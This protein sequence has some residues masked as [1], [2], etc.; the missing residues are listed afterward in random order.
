MGDGYLSNRVGIVRARRLLLT[1]DGG[2]LITRLLYCDMQ[3][4]PAGEFPMALRKAS[5]PAGYT[6]RNSTD[7]VWRYP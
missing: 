6:V 1:S 7:L 4:S 2:L 5:L 3:F